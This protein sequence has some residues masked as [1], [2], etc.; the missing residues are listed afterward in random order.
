MDIL[1]TSAELLSL[2][3]IL[4]AFI[5]VAYLAAKVRTVRSFQFEMFLFLL[6]LGVAE[7]PRVLSSINMID[8]GGI[9]TYGMEAHSVSMVILSGF[10]A[11]RIYGFFKGNANAVK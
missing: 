4:G 1:G 3:F 5:I 8:L 9:V 6:V 11:Y 10:V 2:F 7:V